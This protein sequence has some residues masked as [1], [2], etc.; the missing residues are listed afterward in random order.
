MTKIIQQ[1]SRG[2]IGKQFVYPNLAVY[3][4]CSGMNELGVIGGDGL[5]EKMKKFL[6]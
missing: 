5:I 6:K 3:P 1:S 2:G 4:N